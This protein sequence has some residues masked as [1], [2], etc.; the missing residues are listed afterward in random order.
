MDVGGIGLCGLN[1]RADG[2]CRLLPPISCYL[3][4]SFAA[5]SDGPHDQMLNSIET[6]SAS[7]EQTNDKRIL[8][9]LEDVL[10]GIQQVISSNQSRA[11]A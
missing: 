11:G 2:P 8:M 9:Q 6:I 4:P 10:A 5:L 7:G 1:V 3:C